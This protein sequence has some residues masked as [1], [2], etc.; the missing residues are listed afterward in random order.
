MNPTARRCITRGDDKDLSEASKFLTALYPLQIVGY[1]L[2]FISNDTRADQFVCLQST[3]TKS[4]A[5]ESGL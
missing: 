4:I 2:F 1:I 5:S 3:E